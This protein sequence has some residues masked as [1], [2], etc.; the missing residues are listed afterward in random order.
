MSVQQFMAAQLRKPS[1]W[2]GS[3]VLS[4][5]MNR[6]NRGVIDST[7]DLLRVSPDHQVLEIGFGGGSA[8][9]QLA[10]RLTSGSVTG[11]D[12]SA[13]MV[14]QAERKF[15]RD[16]AAGRVQVQAG[17]V[18][19]LPFAD[20][21]FDR[22]FTI[23][24]IYFWPDA[25]QGLSE[26]RRV[27]KPGGIAAVSLR[28]KQKMKKHRV[29]QYG[30]RLFSPEDVTALIRQAGFHDVMLEHRNQDH[31]YDDVIVLGTK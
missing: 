6:V 30:F 27:L 3:L 22:V 9:V 1:G 14:L 29:T 19:Q 28:S 8:L 26:I 10:K 25:L 21:S 7:I 24:T 20:S 16:I 31:W 12:S 23:N 2:F 13:D 17:D 18:S 11:V 4:R 5:I 15:R